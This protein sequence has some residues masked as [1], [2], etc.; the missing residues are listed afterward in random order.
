M[1]MKLK[2]MAVAILAGCV[3]VPMFGQRFDSYSGAATVSAN[4]GSGVLVKDL[5]FAFFGLGG[6]VTGNLGGTDVVCSPQFP[7]TRGALKN[8][9][10]GT[11]NCVEPWS[12]GPPKDV[13]PARGGG[14]S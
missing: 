13:V 14:K 1:K 6:N 5:S 12:L 7:G 2:L 8:I 3:T 9:G 11:T 4:R 10:G